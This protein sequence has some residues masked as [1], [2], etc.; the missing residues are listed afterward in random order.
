[1]AEIKMQLLTVAGQVLQLFL[2]IG[3]GAVCRRTKLLDDGA[4]RGIV[5]LLLKLVTPALMI[6][7]FQRPLEP[8]LVGQLAAAFAVALLLHLLMIAIAAAVYRGDDAATPVHRLAVVF[9]NGGFM[10]IPLEMALLGRDGVFYG[11]IYVAVFNLV[12]WSWGL[13]VMRGGRGGGSRWRAL[14]NPGVLGLSVALPLFLGSVALPNFV[15]TPIRML[16]DLNTPLAMLV[17]GY[18]LAGTNPL[19]FL[20]SPAALGSSVLR[21]A[22][23]P[24]LAIAV[25]AALGGFVDRTLALALVIAASAPVAAMV[26]MFAAK[27]GRDVEL[28]VALVSGTTLLSVVSMPAVITLARC[29]LRGAGD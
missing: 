14:L 22:V 1:M 3:V 26:T 20:K 4:V 13:K 6:E 5:N 12:I 25:C 27:F 21:L 15:R 19:K 18:Y 29:V 9:S 17:I 16:S 7:C 24:L 10:G 2:L 28:A 8:H 11:V 23:A